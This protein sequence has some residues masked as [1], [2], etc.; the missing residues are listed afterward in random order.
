M[1][2]LVF[3]AA[4]CVLAGC[5]T[6][7]PPASASAQPPAQWYAPLPHNGTLTD[8]SAW[9]AQWD[10]PLLV[11]LIESAQ[12]ANPTIATAASRIRQARATR[13]AAGAAL[14]PTLDAAGSVSR[15][16]TQPP[17]PLATIAQGGL[18]TA[19][20]IDLFGGGRAT[21]DAAQARLEGASANWHAAR[22]SIAAE[23]AT[24]YVTLRTCEEQRVVAVNDAKSRADVTLAL[25]TIAAA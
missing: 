13:V 5:S 24:S 1:K 21:A 25:Q 2:N 19:W 11:E 9:W 16:N 10:D 3:L 8:L 6:P 4:A 18:Q 17:V 7:R 23:A 12:A 14:L 20:E 15:G 22:V